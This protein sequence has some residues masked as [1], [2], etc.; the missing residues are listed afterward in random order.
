M[1]R[2][3]SR[4]KENNIALLPGYGTIIPKAIAENHHFV[5]QKKKKERNVGC[6]HIL[7]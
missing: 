5:S 3:S 2:I 6:H 4:K 1:L 7:Q